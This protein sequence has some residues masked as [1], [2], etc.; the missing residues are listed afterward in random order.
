[1]IDVHCHLLPGLDDGPPDVEAALEQARAHVAAGVETVICTPHVDWEWQ[2]DA[3]TIA[4]RVEELR[5]ALADA[6]IPLRIEAGAEVGLTRAL[7]LPDDELQRL[8]L[9]GGE[10]LL[11]EAPLS[12][13]AA[14]EQPIA[15]VAMRGHRILLAHPE[16]SPA[17]QRDPESLRRLV[18]AG[19]VR[20]QIT[21][22]SLTGAFGSTVQRFARQLVREGLVD[23][24]A[25]DAHDARRRPPGLREAIVDAG[26]AAAAVAMTVDAPSAILNGGRMPARPIVDTAGAGGRRWPWRR[27]SGR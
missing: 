24:V 22:T 3:A 19:T 14:V 20:T 26:F 18:N 5:G 9:A 13:S 16:R 17:F 27:R 6:G 7:D 1:V 12:V 11:L 21:A 25:S 2:V 8:R 15:M 23:I 4:P 10:W